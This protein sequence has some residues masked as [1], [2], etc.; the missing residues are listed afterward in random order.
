MT[1]SHRSQS[2]ALPPLNDV[3]MKVGWPTRWA[4]EDFKKELETSNSKL[5]T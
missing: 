2:W 4:K 5:E 3:A 1:S